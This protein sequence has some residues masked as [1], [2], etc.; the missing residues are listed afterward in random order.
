MKHLRKYNEGIENKDYI[1]EYMD[2]CFIDF[3]DKGALSYG[4]EFERDEEDDDID[5]Y[6]Y[7]IEMR[8]PDCWLDSGRTL[9]ENI[10]SSKILTEFYLDI[11]NSIDKVK[12]E[13]PNIET[14]YTA[15]QDGHSKEV[16]IL[17]IEKLL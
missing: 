2:A 12:L 9:E 4:Q 14:I 3:I 10:K 13:Y 16:Q 7:E 5:E 17:F 15:S 1:K 6:K 11:E 8:V